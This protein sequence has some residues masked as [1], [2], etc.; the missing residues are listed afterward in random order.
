MRFYLF[1][2]SSLFCLFIHFFKFILFY[3]YFIFLGPED[4]LK[5]L[6]PSWMIKGGSTNTDTSTNIIKNTDKI[7][8]KITDKNINSSADITNE[9]TE[10]TSGI[11][12]KKKDYNEGPTLE[13]PNNRDPVEV[14]QHT[15]QGLLHPFFRLR[16]SLGGKAI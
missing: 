10:I 15:F 7:L 12:K 11:N 9:I 4:P 14:K 8:K 5:K 2:I 6:L 16:S 3:F 13:R 1:V